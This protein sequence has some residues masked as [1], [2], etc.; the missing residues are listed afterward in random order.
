[1]IVSAHAEVFKCSNTDG[2]VEYQDKPCA[3]GIVSKRV[4]LAPSP[5]SAEVFAAK[6]IA[7]K[8]SDALKKANPVPVESFYNFMGRA[9]NK[10]KMDNIQYNDSLKQGDKKK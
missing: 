1:M 8:D 5:T 6:Q 7:N 2:K 3:A 9:T 10:I 4:P